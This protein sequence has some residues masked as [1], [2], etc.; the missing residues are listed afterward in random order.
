MRSIHKLT[1]SPYTTIGPIK[2]HKALQSTVERDILPGTGIQANQFWNSLGRVLVEFTP[3]NEAL[4][5]KRDAIQAQIDA[6]LWENKTKPWDAGKYTAFLSEIGYLVPS[7]GPGFKVETENVDAEISSTPGPQL[8]VPVDNARFA[9]NAANARWGSLLDAFYGT[10]A[11]EIPDSPELAKGG[12]YNPKR[13]ALVYNKCHTFLDET[14]PLAQGGKFAQVT[15]VSVNPTSGALQFQLQSGKVVPLDQDSQF[16]GHALGK[17]GNLQFVYL[18][19]NS[20]HVE[21][22]FN[23]QSVMGKDHLAG[24]CGVNLESAVT[25]IADCEDS[26]AAV[27]AQDKAKV[28]H[29]WA[30]LMRGT[31]SEKLSA[32]ST[33]SL[34][35]DKV[36]IARDGSK[37]TLK[38]RALLLVRNVGLHVRNNAVLLA[39]NN[40]PVF[41]GLLDC[42]VTMLAARL[43]FAADKPQN[44]RNS[45]KKSAYM[46]KPKMHGPEEVQFTMDMLARVE[47]ELQ[48][49]NETIKLG[50]M[51]EERRT[52]VNL[53]ECIRVAKRRCIFINTGFLDRTGDEIHTSFVYGPVLPKKEIENASW[54]LAYEDWN[55][56]IGLEV[57]LNRV[58]QIGKGMWAAPDAML[59]MM[60][61]KI[62]HPRAGA[63][64]AWVPSP[65][66]ATLH[67]MHYHAQSVKVAQDQIK[68]VGTRGKLSDIL[69]P[70][71][72]LFRKLSE[73]EVTNEVENNA[74]GMLGYV[75]RWIQL[76]VGCSKV[77]DLHDIGLMEDRA[78]LRISSQ[79]IANWIE[80]GL[81]T[82]E[83]VVEIFEKMAQV[84]DRQNAGSAGY[85][86]MGTGAKLHADLGFRCALEMVFRGKFEP[87]G[88]TEGT[89][90]E[91]RRM[92][93]AN[94]SGVAKL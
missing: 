27:D 73:Q 44:L 51:D 78:T 2:V 35:Q 29:N 62:A 92:A 12:K 82:K 18:L 3:R 67:A 45:H 87:N 57:G 50:I 36:Y 68:Q 76:G 14:F 60:R 8:V 79:H 63:T 46:V 23:R 25:A 65:T 84:V 16:V 42:M 48:L 41:E 24:L 30:G 33:R 5:R 90:A 4:L 26:V 93:K 22:E 71:F 39:S 6:Y 91:F 58:G 1:M 38:G 85:T 37:Q 19:Q 52:T 32:T 49:P 53:K 34:N 74:Q 69:T 55:V 70:P 64:T 72:L 11:G 7:S 20:L 54:R 31:L 80:H 66:A 83:R 94:T 86:A 75:S 9:L 88:L 17:Q 28:Y 56:D 43:D 47:Q 40:S 10:D 77:P 21:L 89:L 15:E 81:V 13:G 59:D 61:K